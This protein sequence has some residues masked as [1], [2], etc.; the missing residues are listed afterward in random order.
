M[1]GTLRHH[2]R[3]GQRSAHLRVHKV[4]LQLAFALDVD[5]AATRADVSESG[6]D[7]ARLLGHLDTQQ[8]RTCT[9]TQEANRGAIVKIF[10][11]SLK[12]KML[13]LNKIHVNNADLFS[14]L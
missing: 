11:G 8:P 2:R 14:T 13:I 5:D 12:F 4:G 3:L 9:H 1:G 6:Q 7:P 10:T